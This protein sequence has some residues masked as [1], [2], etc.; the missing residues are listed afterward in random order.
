MSKGMT[1]LHSHSK[2]EGLLGIENKYVL[3]DKEYADLFE[4]ED[5]VDIILYENNLTYYK[6]PI[7]K[8]YKKNGIFKGLME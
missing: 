8:F 2:L 6:V 4:P 7:Y 5:I 3:I 1:R